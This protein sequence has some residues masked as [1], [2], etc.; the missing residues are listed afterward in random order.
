MKIPTYTLPLQGKVQFEKPLTVGSFVVFYSSSLDMLPDVNPKVDIDNT[1]FNILTADGDY[2]L[3]ISLRRRENAIVFNSRTASGGWGDEERVVLEGI[4]D[5]QQ[6]KAAVAVRIHE[7]SFAIYFDGKLRKSY[8]K[9]IIKDAQ[10]AAYACNSQSVFSNPVTVAVAN[11]NDP[12]PPA[13]GPPARSYQELYFKT[14]ASKI[15]E[16]STTRPYDIVIIGSGIGGGVLAADLLEKNRRLLASRS[17]FAFHAIGRAMPMALNN[18]R[19]V[20]ATANDSDNRSLRILVIERGGLVFNT[21]SLNMPRPTSRGTYGQMNDLFYHAF[22]D[23]W[24]L[25]QE[26]SAKWD[27]GPVYCLGGRSTVWGLFSPRSV[28]NQSFI[29]RKTDVAVPQDE[30]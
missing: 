28:S 7:T 14:E 26:R 19:M 4:F 8:N 29:V 25:D 23:K 3:H 5:S 12:E 16:E 10:G 22:R 27:G 15:A 30:R 6:T 11:V 18:R 13:S 21:H 2:L 24:D 20:E 1:S 17:N 9:R